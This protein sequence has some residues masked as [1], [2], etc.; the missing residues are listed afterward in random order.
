M[1]CRRVLFRSFA[2]TLL[3]ECKIGQQ[4][5]MIDH[6]QIRR[7]R[8]L[9]RLDHKAVVPERAIAAQTVF[10]GGSDLSDQ[11]GVFGQV[12]QLGQIAMSGAARPGN[13][14]LQTR[15]LLPAERSEEHTS[16]L[17]SLMRSSYAVYCLKK[18]TTIQN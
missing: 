6:H 15:Q 7:L 11:P 8:L 16:E 5:V 18:K 14:L 1:E 9:P 10:G 13:D 4:Q 3:L 2:Q 12:A 17:Q